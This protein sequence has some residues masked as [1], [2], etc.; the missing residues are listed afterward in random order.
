MCSCSDP[1]SNIPFAQVLYANDAVMQSFYD[2]LSDNGILVMQ[3]G[4]SAENDAP[5]E[6]NS[7]GKNRAKTTDLL[8]KVG[9]QSI[10]A[11]EEVSDRIVDSLQQYFTSVSNLLTF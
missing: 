11:Y 1:E 5:S 10:H 6:L 8:T 2:S 3:L 9:F 4:E 7:M